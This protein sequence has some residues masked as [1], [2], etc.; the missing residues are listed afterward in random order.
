MLIVNCQL[1]ILNSAIKKMLSFLLFV[2]LLVFLLSSIIRF[3]IGYQDRDT[4]ADNFSN[5]RQNSFDE[6]RI[7]IFKNPE[8]EKKKSKKELL[9]DFGDYTDFEEIP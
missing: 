2:I 6:G 5:M 3:V 7:R 9:K 8:P 4:F 1:S